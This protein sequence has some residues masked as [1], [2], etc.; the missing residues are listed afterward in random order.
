MSCSEYVRAT[1]LPRVLEFLPEGSS[2]SCRDVIRA[3]VYTFSCVIF[4]GNASLRS[5]FSKAL[6]FALPYS[7]N[8]LCCLKFT[9]SSWSSKT[10]YTLAFCWSTRADSIVNKLLY[11]A[12]DSANTDLNRTRR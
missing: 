8:A 3:L 9:T 1:Y 12:G 4:V 11:R 5:S 7:L 6:R 2:T 10:S